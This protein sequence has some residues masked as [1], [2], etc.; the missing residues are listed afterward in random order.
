MIRQ[1][2]DDLQNYFSEVLSLINVLVYKAK[3][4]TDAETVYVV[5][6][7]LLEGKNCPISLN[8][9]TYEVAGL[10]KKITESSDTEYEANLISILKNLIQK[11]P[12]SILHKYPYPLHSELILALIENKRLA[13]NDIGKLDTSLVDGIWV[14]YLQSYK[15]IV[16]GE[17]AVTNPQNLKSITG[18]SL[19]PWLTN[20]FD[21]NLVK[22]VLSQI[23]SE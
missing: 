22:I 12:D 23:Q 2:F 11:L 7:R 17:G 14:Q 16:Y 10:L 8:H 9:L 5:C 6:R 4:V 19:Y 15:S 3:A 13:L 1:I 20:F 21:V 18:V